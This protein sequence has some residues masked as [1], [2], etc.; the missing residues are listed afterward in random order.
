VWAVRW[1]PALAHFAIDRSIRAI[2]KNA[3]QHGT[4]REV[5]Q[6]LHGQLR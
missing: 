3:V 5:E 2:G 6:H 4:K 1:F